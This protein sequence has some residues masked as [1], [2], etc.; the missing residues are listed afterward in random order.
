MTPAKH[1]YQG[2]KHISESPK[3]NI[4]ISQTEGY[5]GNWSKFVVFYACGFQARLP[6]QQLDT[7]VLNDLVHVQ[8]RE[9]LILE[10]TLECMAP[11]IFLNSYVG[12]MSR[13]LDGGLMCNSVFMCDISLKQLN[14]FRQDSG[15]TLQRSTAETEVVILALICQSY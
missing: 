2:G 8:K 14:K 7:N 4:E 1:V 5:S 10:S 13:G 15:A 6:E 11:I 3:F 9:L 12:I